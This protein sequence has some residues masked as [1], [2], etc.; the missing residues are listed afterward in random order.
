MNKI[1]T[2]KA[3]EG[4]EAWSTQLN[5]AQWIPWF[6]KLNYLHQNLIW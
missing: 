6:E 3:T 4:E 5:L 2:N 1:S